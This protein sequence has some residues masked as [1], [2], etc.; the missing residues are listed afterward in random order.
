MLAQNDDQSDQR[1][2]QQYHRLVGAMEYRQG[3]DCQRILYPTGTIKLLDITTF[4]SEFTCGQSSGAI[5]TAMRFLFISWIRGQKCL[6]GV[7][8]PSFFEQLLQE[9]ESYRLLVAHPDIGVRVALIYM[10]NEVQLNQQEKGLATIRFD[11]ILTNLCVEFK[12][13]TYFKAMQLLKRYISIL[14]DSSASCDES[15]LELCPEALA[16]VLQNE[17]WVIPWLWK[18]KDI[19]EE[20]V[21]AVVRNTFSISYILLGWQLNTTCRQT[22]GY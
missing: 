15:Q 21:M 22:R 11:V 1:Q 20:F 2:P 19:D 12:P 13:S 17:E 10:Y 16:P 3:L 7:E 5:E 18:H 9:S 8:D 6:Y 4:I 14:S